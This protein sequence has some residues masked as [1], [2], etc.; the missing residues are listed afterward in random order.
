M[1]D[2]VICFSKQS[3]VNDHHHWHNLR[4]SLLSFSNSYPELGI[5]L[6]LYDDSPS[7]V[8]LINHLPS[9]FV[10]IEPPKSP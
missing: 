3:E 1:V 10:L 7:S 4:N 2:V 8:L 6:Y 9:F 5:H